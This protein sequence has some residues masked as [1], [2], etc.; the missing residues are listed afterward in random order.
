VNLLTD[1]IRCSEEAHLPYIEEEARIR[2]KEEKLEGML[3]IAA[4]FVRVLR[5]QLR[6]MKISDESVC[7]LSP[8]DQEIQRCLRD[9]SLSGDSSLS[10]IGAGDLYL[11]AEKMLRIIFAKQGIAIDDK[12]PDPLQIINALIELFPPTTHTTIKEELTIATSEGN[13]R[14]FASFLKEYFAEISSE[15]FTLISDKAPQTRR[16]KRTRIPWQETPMG[17]MILESL[18]NSNNGGSGEDSQAHL[19]IH[20]EASA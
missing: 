7:D 11:M 14:S 9:L 12:T 20:Q 10:H 2:A 3:E 15:N 4:K 13:T 8:F 6:D 5:K 18:H 17:R 19:N 16:K 1:K